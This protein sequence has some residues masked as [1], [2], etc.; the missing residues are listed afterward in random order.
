M[1]T[2]TATNTSASNS[3]LRQGNATLSQVMASVA[4]GASAVTTSFDVIGDASKVA[5]VHSGDWL[6]NTQVK[7]A[8][9]RVLT[10][11]LIANETT[12]DM[13][14]RIAETTKKLGQDPDLKAAYDA[15]LPQIEV[16]IAAAGK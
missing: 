11:T 10:D 3:A 15:I 2:A 9:K 1:S 16:A 4:A 12:L 7:S 5:K 6:R 14:T 8:A 13:A